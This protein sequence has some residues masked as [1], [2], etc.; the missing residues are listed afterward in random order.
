[1]KKTVVFKI[2]SFLLIFYLFFVGCWDSTTE[3]A[4]ES[5]NPF[6]GNFLFVEYRIVTYGKRLKDSVGFYLGRDGTC[7]NYDSSESIIWIDAFSQ[8]KIDTV[9]RFIIGSVIE[10]CPEIGQGRVGSIRGFKSFNLN[11]SVYSPPFTYGHQI[12][13]IDCD[14]KGKTK[15]AFNNQELTLK[16]K[17]VFQ[18]TISRSNVALQINNHIYHYDYINDIIIIRNFGFIDKKNIRYY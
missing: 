13:M 2:L 5:I 18:D 10:L 15:M 1:M 4:D 17:E 12:R 11:D 14:M 16:P 9:N 3:P 7:Y 8:G 6:N